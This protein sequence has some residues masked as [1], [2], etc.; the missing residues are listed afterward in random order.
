[1]I[2][3]HHSQAHAPLTSAIAGGN[4]SLRRTAIFSF[5]AILAT[6]AHAA[7]LLGGNPALAS[8]LGVATWWIGSAMVLL[9]LYAFPSRR[10]WV[11]F[12]WAF[13]T[14]I[15][16]KPFYQEVLYQ[17]YRGVDRGFNVTLPDL[18]TFGTFAWVM[19]G[20]MR[21]PKIWL[22]YNSLPWFVVILISAISIM[23]SKV[24]LL[25]LFTVHKFIVCWIL[26]WTVVNVVR[27]RRDLHA[28]VSGLM[29]CI[30]VQGIWVLISKYGLGVRVYRVVGFFDHPNSLAMYIELILPVLLAMLL[31]NVVPRRQRKWILFALALG[32]V[33]IIFTRS[34][35]ALVISLASLVGVSAVSFLGRPSLHQVKIFA[36]GLIVVTAI[37]VKAA[38]RIIERFKKAPKE[39]GETR[40]D[41]NRVAV[42][43]ARD[44]PFGVGINAYSWM[45]GNS[46]YYN[47]LYMDELKTVP[48]YD[49]FRNSVAGQAK[50]GTA[51]HI[52]LLFAAETG[53]AGM[54]AFIWF[55]VMFYIR[56]LMAWWRAKDPFLKAFL[57]GLLAGMTAIHLSGLLEWVWR[58]TQMIYLFFMLNGLLVVSARFEPLVARRSPRPVKSDSQP[59]TAEASTPSA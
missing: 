19:L 15:I 57:L 22:P 35:A 40:D 14:G 30:I 2:R 34:R 48:D 37:G 26:Y 13:T 45:L 36:L 42:A 52:Y 6:Q 41:F 38:P 59:R 50:L 51:H 46:H 12:L 17:N 33:C 23:H 25:S 54:A 24:P 20:G 3:H 29:W 4:S 16:V 28:M 55:L 9:A 21:R 44:N 43:M 56:N 27:D 11:L 53:W 8:S 58:Q 49:A 1:M 10:H 32:V 47:V 18:F 7:G 5:W 31:A 39:S